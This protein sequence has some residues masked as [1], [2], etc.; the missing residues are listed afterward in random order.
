MSRERHRRDLD[1]IDKKILT[2]LQKNGRAT[3]QWLARQIDLS[4]TPCLE[5]V[6][7]LEKDGFIEGYRATVV[8]EA[9]GCP[10]LIYALISFD[11]AVDGVYE[12]FRKEIAQIKEIVECHMVTGNVDF[13]MKIRTA[14]INGFRALLEDKILKLP[15]VRITHSYV[16]MHEAKAESMVPI[17]DNGD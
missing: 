3:N 2:L 12:K 16:A 4:P 10:M 5:R 6:R 9:V 11:Y 15:G 17:L 1:Q 8:P 7:R 13:I 14:D